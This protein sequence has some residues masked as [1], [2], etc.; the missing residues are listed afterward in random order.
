MASIIHQIRRGPRVEWRIFFLAILMLCGLG[1]LGGKLWWEQVARG[2]FWTKKIAGRS[3]VT[4][5]IPSV[6]GEIRDRNG[7][8]L[9]ANKASYEVDFYLP[10]MVKGFKDQ[11]NGWVPVTTYK[12]PVRQMLTEKYEADVVQIVNTS[13]IPRLQELEVAKDY[14]SER[15][16][17]HYRN[18]TEVPFTYLEG[19]DFPT[20]AKFAEHNVGLP[21]VDFSI[22]PVREYR[23]KALAAHLLGYVGAPN[24]IDKLPDVD[25]YTYYQPDVE[26]K[27]QVELALDKWIRGTPGVKVLR[28]SVKG[29]I[30][31]EEKELS[32]LPQPGN[33]IY[34]T[35][36]ARIQYIAERALRDAGIG[37][38]AAVV[39]DPNT[40]EIL[41]MASVPSYDPNTFIPSISTA[42]W[43][44]VNDDDTDPL[45]NRAILGYA[46]GSTFKTVT[47][48][49][50]LRAGLDPRMTL[51]CG[52]GYTYGNKFMMCWVTAQHM[53]P[54]GGLNLPDALKNS[55]NSF[56]YQ[57]G[58]KAKIDNILAVA[59]S[60]G[61]GQS[62]GVP[63]SGESSGLIPGPKWLAQ[64]SPGERWSEGY[65]ANVSIGQGAVE[66][67]PLQ[68]AMVTAT[69]ANRG[70]SY[71]PKLVH[72]VLNQEGQDVK[73]ENGNLVMPH[74]PK[75]RDDLHKAGITDSQIELVREGMKRVVATG[76][77]KKAQI[78]G[79][80]VAGKT[81]TAQFWR[82]EK[83]NGKTVKIKDNHTWFI[84]FAPYEQP[85]YAVC[86]FVQGAKSGGGVSAPIAQKIMEESLALEKGF[87][88]GLQALEPAKGSFRP[89]EL[90]DYKKSVVP[91]DQKPEE[92]IADSTE[93]ID[94]KIEKQRVARPDI[95]AEADQGGRIGRRQ[96]ATPPPPTEKIG[97]FQRFFGRKKEAAPPPP[98]KPFRPGGR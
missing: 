58:N 73:D 6:R 46:P 65:T 47:A 96:V 97:F 89:I 12:A 92:E 54:H 34:L 22:R 33:N 38:G 86:I 35:I 15:L 40:G 80:T 19:I 66:A 7:I 62:T 17:K 85:K 23:F 5:R 18:N 4:V 48:L 11:H 88:P 43:E 57:W 67:S 28:R 63:L 91:T 39:V 98:I 44:T 52:G 95:R 71:Y 75:I 68:M 60:L 42:D 1:V 69:I 76:T 50:G 51:N 24:D 78:K 81:G 56:F 72:R 59:D 55:C 94:K 2:P 77:G 13:I 93:I 10:S 20:V 90:V 64:V 9:V 84:T 82:L 87:D 36:D 8:T 21:G 31:G 26:G 45:T 37:R 16:Q 14:N 30:E 61:L 49:A 32:V 29:V 83:E 70:I 74:G 41:A 25:K 53:A 27:A 3:Q 79:I